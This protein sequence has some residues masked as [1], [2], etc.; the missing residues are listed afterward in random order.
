MSSFTDK[1]GNNFICNEFRWYLDILGTINDWPLVCSLCS[2]IYFYFNSVHKC[3]YVWQ[4]M[5]YITH[6]T[7]V[8][9]FS[10]YKW[11][12]QMDIISTPG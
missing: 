3:S 6:K 1:L 11:S 8:G 4:K 2:D 9:N 5:H 7:A 10:V 12:Q